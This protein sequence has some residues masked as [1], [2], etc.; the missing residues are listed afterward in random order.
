M[1]AFG[2]QAGQDVHELMVVVPR[3]VRLAEDD[4]A[5]PAHEADVGGS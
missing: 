5:I 1:T 4:L 2:I 3:R